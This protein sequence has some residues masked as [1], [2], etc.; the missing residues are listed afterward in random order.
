V[1][2]TPDQEP[3]AEGA[4]SADSQGGRSPLVYVAGGLA[5]LF[6]LC[7]CGGGISG[8]VLKLMQDQ[9]GDPVEIR[10]TPSDIDQPIERVM[11]VDSDD[12]PEP[13]PEDEPEPEPE[14][15]PVREPVETRPQDRPTTPREPRATKRPDPEPEPVATQG[16]DVKIVLSESDRAAIRCGDGQ[17]VEFTGAVRMS[18]ES[19]QSCVITSGDAKGVVSVRNSGQATCGRVG[20]TI[21]CAGP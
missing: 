18:F 21:T 19:A 15:E 2:W 4:E 6:L 7:L 11:T 20:S 1:A 3:A 14:A 9:P 5:V 10:T 13:E 17:S 12:E 16:Y 8:A